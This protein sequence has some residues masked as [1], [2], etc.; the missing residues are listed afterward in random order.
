MGCARSRRASARKPQSSERRCPSA[1]TRQAGLLDR[2]ARW[3]LRHWPVT[4]TPTPRSWAA[5][6]RA[7]VIAPTTATRATN[8]ASWTGGRGHRVVEA[9]E[10]RVQLRGQ[11][12]ES[13]GGRQRAGHAERA[14][15]L[16]AQ[17]FGVAPAARGGQRRVEPG[18]ESFVE[19]EVVGQHADP[20]G[21]QREALFVGETPGTVEE[22]GVETF[23]G[24]P[25]NEIRPGLERQSEPLHGACEGQEPAVLLG[26]A[27]EEGGVEESRRRVGGGWRERG[28]LVRTVHR[29]SG[30]GE[31][32]VAGGCS[33]SRA[34]GTGQD[35]QR[36][37]R[38]AH[39][40]R[41]KGSQAEVKGKRNPGEG[42]TNLACGL[43]LVAGTLPSLLWTIPL[44]LESP[45]LQ[46]LAV[47]VGGSGLKAAVLDAEGNMLTER[48]RVKTPPALHARGVARGNHQARGHAERTQFQPHLGGFPGGDPPGGH[49]HGGEPR[50]GPARVSPSRMN[51]RNTWGTPAG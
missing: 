10:F 32:G 50:R 51:C 41:E 25:G 49:P 12:V 3:L 38:D 28:P 44:P 13:E 43:A 5:R 15:F 37:G 1:T 36:G 34:D 2:Q 16:K 39:P 14:A 45:D 24:E 23:G 42:W 48:V 18:G 30:G 11:G 47:D 20:G 21:L 4:Y 17:D 8:G 6:T 31:T 35:A 33:F 27:C 29:F 19:G 40:T 7:S 26:R 9:V 46:I 22:K